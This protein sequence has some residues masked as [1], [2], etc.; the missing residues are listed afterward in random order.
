MEKKGKMTNDRRDDRTGI[1]K[2]KEG[3]KGNDS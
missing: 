1:R 3:G 2:G